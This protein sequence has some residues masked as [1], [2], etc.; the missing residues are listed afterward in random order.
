MHTRCPYRYYQCYRQHWHPM[1]LAE[2]A[3]IGSAVHAALRAIRE[4][5]RM[6]DG[7]DSGA[8]YITALF[9][10]PDPETRDRLFAMVEVLTRGY[11]LHLYRDDMRTVHNE[12][13]LSAPLGEANAVAKARLDGLVFR[14][15][16]APLLLE[17]KS[18]SET[19]DAKEGEL[20]KALQ[21]PLYV[22][23]AE[24]ALGHTLAGAICEVVKKPV[25]SGEGAVRRRK[26][27]TWG[28]WQ[29]RVADEY[30]ANPD[31]YFRRVMIPR[32]QIDTTSAVAALQIVAETVAL[33]DRIGYPRVR[34]QCDGKYGPCPYKR[35]CWYGDTEGYEQ[36]PYQFDGDQRKGLN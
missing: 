13:D 34:G 8:A 7:L 27:E 35:L 11:Y 29:V 14:L 24:Q 5:G 9:P 18:T 33:H 17:V 12:I 10:P 23:L 3:T 32:S 1:G 36:R 6:Q 4:S 30:R 19:L 21:V 31:R 2:A 22:W 15:G 20:C 25:G 28:D 16:K 26:E